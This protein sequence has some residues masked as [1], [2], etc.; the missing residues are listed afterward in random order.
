MNS[1][2]MSKCAGQKI[3][4]NA[5]SSRFFVKYLPEIFCVRVLFG[6]SYPYGMI[7]Q[8]KFWKFLIELWNL[9]L[10]LIC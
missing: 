10:F 6:I 9:T 1:G 7:S 3:S 5:F 8:V 2:T 4:S